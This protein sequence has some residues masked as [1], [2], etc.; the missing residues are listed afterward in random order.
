MF[1]GLNGKRV[2]ERQTGKDKSAEKERKLDFI[3]L[4]PHALC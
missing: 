3:L 4:S 1:I 2:L